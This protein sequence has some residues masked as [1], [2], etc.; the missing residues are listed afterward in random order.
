MDVKQRSIG[1]EDEASEIRGHYRLP[2]AGGCIKAAPGF[3]TTRGSPLSSGSVHVSIIAGKLMTNTTSHMIH[4]GLSVRVSL[5]S[6]AGTHR[7]T[8]QYAAAKHGRATRRNRNAAALAWRRKA[9]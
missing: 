3:K 4:T 7:Y 8:I 5:Q 1:I 2:G 6:P 9:I